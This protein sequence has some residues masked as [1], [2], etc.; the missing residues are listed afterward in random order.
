MFGTECLRLQWDALSKELVIM[1][2]VI[3]RKLYSWVVCNRL[4][5][6]GCTYVKYE[7]YPKQTCNM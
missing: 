5:V 3:Y 1:F 4:Y 2:L 6:I 7:N